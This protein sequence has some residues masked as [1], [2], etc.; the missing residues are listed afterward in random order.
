MS[1]TAPQQNHPLQVVMNTVESGLGE[2]TQSLDQHWIGDDC[3]STP[4]KT[5]LL[6]HAE[7]NLDDD[8]GL[9]LLLKLISSRILTF[10]WWNIH[11]L[12]LIFILKI[13]YWQVIVQGHKILEVRLYFYT[14]IFPLSGYFWHVLIFSVGSLKDIRDFAILASDATAYKRHETKYV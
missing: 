12:F 10:Y 9:L 6:L 1:H 11:G 2:T 5:I 14:L 4:W 7:L 8:G 3:D 13:H